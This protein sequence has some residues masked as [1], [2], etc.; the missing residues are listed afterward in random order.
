MTAAND[1]SL[2]DVRFEPF[3][4]SSSMPSVIHGNST[5]DSTPT[6]TSSSADSS[7]RLPS[8]TYHR[9]LQR[10]DEFFWLD[11]DAPLDDGIIDQ[12]AINRIP[13][14]ELRS[15][16][17]ISRGLRGRSAA[18]SHSHVAP[19][20]SP[21]RAVQSV[22]DGHV[23]SSTPHRSRDD[24]PPRSAPHPASPRLSTRSRHR[25]DPDVLDTTRRLWL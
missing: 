24:Q 16:I 9:V 22:L 2:A 12:A 23:R 13:S 4:D 14:D 5:R 17:G 8:A 1:G 6:A 21:D 7:R 15:D 19:P 10:L 20:P 18:A 3:T 25:E 11:R